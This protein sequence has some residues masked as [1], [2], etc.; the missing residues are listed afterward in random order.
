MLDMHDHERMVMFHVMQKASSFRRLVFPLLLTFRSPGGGVPHVRPAN[1]R[2]GPAREAGRD[3]RL[4]GHAHE[5]RTRLFFPVCL[6]RTWAQHAAEE[7]DAVVQ[8]VLQAGG[9]ALPAAA[10]DHRLPQRALLVQHGREGQPLAVCA[11]FLSLLRCLLF[12][13]F[14]LSLFLSF[15]LFRLS[16]FCFV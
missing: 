4:H 12:N 8:R 14:D 15:S 16:L 10:P 3:Q 2:D 7:G 13:L 5:V 1:A 9:A 6:L 11:L